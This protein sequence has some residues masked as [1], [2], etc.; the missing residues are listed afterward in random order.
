M[1]KQSRL[2]IEGIDKRNELSVISD[3]QKG[4]NEYNESHKDALSDGDPQ[5]KG[6]GVPLGMASQPGSTTNK[7]ISYANMDTQHGGGS[8]DI[9]GRNGVGGRKYLST[10]NLYNSDSAYGPE[11]IDTSKNVA[12]GQLVIR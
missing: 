7:G 6:T 3:Y 5:G 2:E 11:S 12:D 8:Y 4:T 9:D 1:A 10:I